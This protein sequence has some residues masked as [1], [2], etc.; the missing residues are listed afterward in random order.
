MLPRQ[1]GGVTNVLDLQAYSRTK[2]RAVHL[3][4]AE[5]QLLQSDDDGPGWAYYIYTG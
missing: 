5:I 4:Q 2:C 3:I 1:W